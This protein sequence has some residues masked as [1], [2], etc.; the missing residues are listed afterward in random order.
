VRSK[1][2]INS[3]NNLYPYS[4]F[5]KQLVSAFEKSSW[6]SNLNHKTLSF[7]IPTAQELYRLLPVTIHKQHEQQSPPKIN[8]TCIHRRTS[9]R[10]CCKAN[11]WMTAPNKL[12]EQKTQQQ[13]APSARCRD[14]LK[15]GQQNQQHTVRKAGSRSEEPSWKR[16]LGALQVG[17]QE[18][19]K[20][21]AAV[22]TER[23]LLPRDEK[24]QIGGV[25]S[26]AETNQRQVRVKSK[27][28][29]WTPRLSAS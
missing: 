10:V 1:T 11:F 19:A 23:L 22:E 26:R 7:L 13:R 9:A 14:R 15:A 27:T 4:Y 2:K 6:K 18:G 24:K 28:G 25:L 20:T 12:G 21:K 3:K 17:G 5:T 8:Q 29:V 16:S